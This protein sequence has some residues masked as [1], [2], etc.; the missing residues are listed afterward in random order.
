MAG[1]GLVHVQRTFWRVPARS[2]AAGSRRPG[3]R[4]CK[5]KK[6]VKKP[7][8]RGQRRVRVHQIVRPQV[9]RWLREVRQ[10]LGPMTHCVN[11]YANPTSAGGMSLVGDAYVEAAL[12]G[13]PR[14]LLDAIVEVV[15]RLQGIGRQIEVV[16]E[17]K[18][19]AAL[20]GT[21]EKIEEMRRRHE[22]FKALHTDG[23]SRRD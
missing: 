21:R 20:P 5:P 3:V 9:A 22:R 7:E 12:A 4:L 17:P 13:D 18:A 2:H 11:V 1:E 16:I 15:C 23:D 10:I 6:V 14:I 19:T 8:T